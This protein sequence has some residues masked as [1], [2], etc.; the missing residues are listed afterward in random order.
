MPATEYKQRGLFQKYQTER[1]DGQPLDPGE[2]LFLIR[3][4][5]NDEWGRFWR[6]HLRD[7]LP[8]LRDLGYQKLAD[9]LLV[10]IEQIEARVVSETTGRIPVEVPSL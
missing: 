9:D 2:R 8:G 3:Y 4:D 6:K 10:E 7:A 1:A 5:K